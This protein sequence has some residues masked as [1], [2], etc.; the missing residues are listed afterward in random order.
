MTRVI[1]QVASR[2]DRT[3]WHREKRFQKFKNIPE[4]NQVENGRLLVEQLD[5]FEL[6]VMDTRPKTNE[7]WARLLDESLAG[8]AKSWRDFAIVNH[9][10]K[11]YHQR[12]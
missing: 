12:I 3:E 11:Y 6:A 7:E 5:S 8:S 1:Q 4:I 9:P 2:N 10:G